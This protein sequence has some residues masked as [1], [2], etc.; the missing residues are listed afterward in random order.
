[1]TDHTLTARSVSTPL[2][3]FAIRALGCVG[4]RVS[5]A[6]L[7]GPR[8]IIIVYPHTS[9]W[10]FPIGLLAKWATGLRVRWLGKE[11]LFRG[12][13]GATL[14][15]LF[16]A[17]GGEPIERGANTGAIERLAQRIKAADEFWLA[18][19]PEGTR[20][21]RDTWR[22]ALLLH[23][24]DCECAAGHC[25]HRLCEQG[26]AAGHVSNTVRRA[27]SRPGANTQRLPRLPRIETGTCG[28]DKVISR[29][30]KSFGMTGAPAAVPAPRPKKCGVSAQAT[31]CAAPTVNRSSENRRKCLNAL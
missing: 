3:R 25:L 10:D 1:M 15:P 12:L 13:C 28:T 24:A 26:S 18:L 2:Q 17:C 11:A 5:F 4:W 30:Q 6:P 9:N 31:A 21:Y 22:S 14:G 8:G 16:R 20:K 29:K 19:A 27:G 7:P 23:R